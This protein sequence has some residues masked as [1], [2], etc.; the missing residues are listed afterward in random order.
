MFI[1]RLQ[2]IQIVN[3]KFKDTLCEDNFVLPKVKSRYH[4]NPIMKPIPFTKSEFAVSH[5]DIKY[6]YCTGF[7]GKTDDES[8]TGR[9]VTTAQL[10]AAAAQ[11]NAAGKLRRASSGRF[12]PGAG[13]S[14][15]NSPGAEDAESIVSDLT[16]VSNLT[17]GQQ[18]YVRDSRRFAFYASKKVEGSDV[19]TE[20]MLRLNQRKTMSG[21]YS[22]SIIESS[23]ADPAVLIGYQVPAHDGY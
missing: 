23:V 9:V 8:V 16:L 22:E 7:Q 15:P 4:G 1:Y 17:D 19:L 13:G 12:T 11:A 14:R 10:Q 3:Q 20:D 21:A 5:V 6:L 18:G 2:I